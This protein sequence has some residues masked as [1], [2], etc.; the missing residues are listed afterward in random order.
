[1]SNFLAIATATLTLNQTIAAAI[2]DAVPGAAVTTLRPDAP[3]DGAPQPRVNLYLYQVTP[4]AAWRNADLPTRRSDSGLIQCP[5]AALDLHYLLTF[6]GDDAQLEPQR[7]LGSVV[8]AI[9]ARPLLTREAIRRTI[10]AAIQTDP[11]HYLAQSDLAEQVELVKFSPLALNLEELS[12]MWSVLFQVPY[13]LSIAYQG[14]VV[15]LEAEG[16][17]QSALPVRVVRVGGGPARLPVITQVEPTGIE[18]APDAQLT[19][20]GE[21]LSAE[22]VSVR[23]GAFEAVPHAITDRE[24]VV[25]LPAGLRA[26]VNSVQVVHKIALAESADLRDIVKSNL[27]TFE[28]APRITSPTPLT[29]ARGG[30]LTVPCAPA[31]AGNQ[32]VSLLIGER[33]LRLPQRPD[34]T[35][36]LALVIPAD[37][38]AG[39]FLFRLRVDGVESRLSTDESGRYSGPIV[40]LT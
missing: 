20:N 26:G 27:A 38:P 17:P 37:F 8:T 15:L 7:L 30:T 21:N 3:G 18:F 22:R 14:S 1:M 39:D 31:I 5:Q 4:N 9:H 29:T 13:A 25:G 33:E 12:K 19:L 28:L 2:Q 34:S 16:T 10:D 24:I 35:E 32:R 36:T 6:F 40:R 11:N 23:F